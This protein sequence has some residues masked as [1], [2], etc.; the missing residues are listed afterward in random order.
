[1]LKQLKQLA[2]DTEGRYA[3]EDE[4]S[5]L[6]DYLASASTRVAAYEKIRDKEEALLDEFEAETLSQDDNA[7]MIGTQNRQSVARRDCKYI[8]RHLAVS[9]LANDLERY[10]DGI[11]VWQRTIM[12]ANR[13]QECSQKVRNSEYRVMEKNFSEEEFQYLKPAL[14]LGKS[15]LQ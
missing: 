7:Y 15:V 12:K 8:L 14:L 5:F 2:I 1:M 10:R 6:K 9:M 11:L 4:L 13:F 3:T